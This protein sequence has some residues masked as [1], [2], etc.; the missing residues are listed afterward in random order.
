LGLSDLFNPFRVGWNPR[1]FPRVLPWAEVLNA[2]GVESNS[3]SVCL[4]AATIGL[5]ESLFASA[6]ETQSYLLPNPKILAQVTHS[7]IQGVAGIARHE[8]EFAARFVVLEV[9]EVFGHLDLIGLH[10]RRELPLTEE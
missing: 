1:S 8:A 4:S 9:P 5:C 10:R 2:F 6:T 3:S 7:I